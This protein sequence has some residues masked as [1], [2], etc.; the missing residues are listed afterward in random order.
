MAFILS[1]FMIFAMIPA[2]TTLA[3]TEPSISLGSAT[4]SDGKYY[5]TNAAVSGAGIQTILVNFSDTVTAGDTITV[6]TAPAGFTVSATSLGNSYSKRINIDTSITGT[7]NAS[8]VQDYVRGIGFAI[9][10]ATQT[11]NITITSQ[12]I[13]YDTFYN[14]DTQ[15]YYQFITYASGTTGAWTTAY[16]A[17]KGM[18]YL[19]RAGYLATVTT[20][21]EDRFLYELSGGATGW[22][23][24][25]TLT[26][27]TQSGNYYESFNTSSNLDHWFWACGPDI[28][29]TFYTAQANSATADSNSVSAGYYFNWGAGE[30]NNANGEQCLTTLLISPS[31]GYTN[32]VSGYQMT[33]FSW[34]NIV[35]DR[36]YA[37]DGRYYARGYFVE[38]GDE[39]L[40]DSK[41]GT[42]V[43]GYASDKGTLR[44]AAGISAVTINTYTD[45]V[46]HDVSGN[47]ELRQGE[48]SITATDVGTGYYT[49]DA[50]SL[51]SG[52]TY[53]IYINDADTDKSITYGGSPV[54]VDVDYYTVTFTVSD[55]GAASDS[56]I[57]AQAGG[58][59][60][61]S[62]A[63]V[64][65]GETVVITTAGVGAD[66][67]TYLW[68]G[69]GTNAETAVS[70][71]I[72]S[73][74]GTVDALC[75][76]TGATII[77]LSN[78]TWQSTTTYT[79]ALDLPSSSRMVT[80]S[81]DSGY[82]TIPSLGTALTY[83]G[84]TNGA[85]YISA[86]DTSTQYNS[87]V[88][89]YSDVPAAETL[90]SAIIYTPKAADA[91][92]TITAT[93][94]TVSPTG[95]DLYFG[96][97]FYRYVSGPISWIDAVLA[98]GGTADPYFGG[99]GYIATATSQAENSILLKLTDTGGSDSDHWYD[100][101]MG[102]LWQ[103]NT[104]SVSS[105]NI[106]RGTNGN[107]ITYSNLL[108]ATNDQRK[109][110]LPDF[111]ITYNSDSVCNGTTSY[112]YAHPETVRYYWIDGPEAGQEIANNETDFSPWHSGEPNGGDFVYI[113]WE[114]AY[115]DDL[116]A[117]SNH[118]TMGSFDTLSGYIVEFS[119]F[120]SGSV[121]GKVASDTQ[122][123][124]STYSVSLNNNGGTVN[125]GNVTSYTYGVGAT[126]PNDVTKY[127]FVFGGWYTDSEFTG[128]PVTTISAT[129][130]GNKIYYAKWTAGYSYDHGSGSG[131]GG[132][133]SS[134]KTI[135]VTEAS[136]DVFAGSPGTISAKA[137]MDNAFSS[138]VEVKVKDTDQE[139]ASFGFA[140]GTDVY[141]FDIS[142]YIKGTNTKTKPAS[143][144]AVTISLPI[145][146]DLLDVREQLF[147]VHKSEDG[148][149]ATLTSSLKQVD[150]IWYMEFEA[151]EFSPYALVKRNL[152]SYNASQGL[153]YYL[154]NG[155]KVFIG[156][157]AYGKYLEPEGMTVKFVP[158]PKNFMDI[159][160]HWGKSYIG[161]VTERE[162]FV[163]TG[164][165]VFSPDTGM[166]RAMFAT[167]IG[168]LYERSYG[169]ISISDARAFTDC[170]YED[171]Y[172]KYVDW[173]AKNGIIQGVG[174]GLFV[175]DRQVT[176]Q[177]MA[178]ML[179]RFAEFAKLSAS[180]STGVT[181]SYSD[182]S[183]IASWAQ[184][185]ALYCQETG[186][187]TGRNGGSFAPA[188]MATRAEVAAII[189]RFV[190][191]VLK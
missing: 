133:S 6:P 97:H 157:A 74:S 69:D 108:G 79:C 114:G 81:V 155:S 1:V 190:E 106:T 187:I 56:T 125:S 14:I 105:S 159:S 66:A 149:V 142:L 130:T 137:N 51:T 17:A 179:Y 120:A 60:I 71:T 45:E 65:S 23:G 39:V 109:N 62:G 122:T 145:P 188:E 91:A 185:A 53:E 93:S 10:G 95:S 13:A 34:N 176:R 146:K 38:Y 175:P 3:A 184:S 174:D 73:L 153:P 113:G 46:L 54:S 191:L 181:L 147:I 47:V 102:G 48:S 29:D 12:N 89:S 83:L 144:Y 140:A 115:W 21:A 132:G 180:T 59:A 118:S 16:D 82:F 129:D 67:Y 177:E 35:Y 148:T 165:N 143:G 19:G 55:A 24:G 107:E 36:G 40:G 41:S 18:T 61:T 84:G 172:G 94:S 87:A 92:Q 186:I 80:I 57:S 170:N 141:P 189:Q 163:G 52:T 27:G 162:I 75:T 111:H 168:R 30:P 101:W 85:S 100:A 8:A 123:V 183:S 70:F 20:L 15:H 26:P 171:Y 124:I 25:T 11:V 43:A 4:L 131:G 37:S 63:V 96:G 139:T 90:L 178:A 103:R 44:S 77:D 128:S 78:V 119:G 161:F 50:G 110:L 42:A 136:S 72:S 116:S 104:G 160:G 88:F 135:T 68:S 167:V 76:V 33:A 7:D 31:N 2:Q 9:V 58:S 99:R 86:F 164:T 126:L 32:T 49:I 121:T 152:S 173:A 64:L 5:Y 158:N 182:A 134:S 151:A 166:T 98:A 156:F 127:G 117:Y 28:G 112:I 138:S 154:N 22:L 150:G 169:Q